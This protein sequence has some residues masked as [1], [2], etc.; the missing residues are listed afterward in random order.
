MTV[1]RLL[2]LLLLAAGTLA[3]LMARPKAYTPFPPLGP[4][5]GVGNVA[6]VTVDSSPIAFADAS[7]NWD[8]S[9]AC[10]EE[11]L[12]YLAGQADLAS[13]PGRIRITLVDEGDL[14]LGVAFP[15]V[16]SPQALV[17]TGCERNENELS[18]Q[19]AVDHGSPGP[20]LDAAVSAA[21]A[22]G[23]HDA[24]RLK[25]PQAWQERPVW[26]WAQFTPILQK[27]GKTWH[28]DCATVRGG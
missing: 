19:V 18:C 5:L 17:L 27:Q 22:V 11:L 20:A 2:A 28:S 1:R 26:S 10:Q 3:F 9:N 7:T 4:T 24:L 21:L 15:D 13:Q 6:P 23:V 25:S 16:E 8:W 14:P 12:A